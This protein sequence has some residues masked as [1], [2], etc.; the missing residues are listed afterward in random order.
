MEMEQKSDGE[1]W[2]QWCSDVSKKE[3]LQINLDA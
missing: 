3:K 1:Q 2:S